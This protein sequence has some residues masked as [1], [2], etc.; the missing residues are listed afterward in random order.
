[1]SLGASPGLSAE[2]LL[3]PAVR[4]QPAQTAARTIR[5]RMQPRRSD[6]S[7]LALAGLKPC[8]TFPEARRGRPWSVLGGGASSAPTAWSSKNTERVECRRGAAGDL[9]QLHRH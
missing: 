4:T 8:A 1:M 7:D 5:V 6:I 9:R 2:T 3:Q